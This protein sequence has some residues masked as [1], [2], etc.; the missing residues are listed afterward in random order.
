MSKKLDPEI[1]REVRELVADG[2]D[3]SAAFLLWFLSNMYRIDKD[4]APDMV[5]DS[6][7][8]KGIDGILVDDATGEVVIFSS[9]FYR[10]TKAKTQGDNDLRNLV[11]ASDWFASP[12]KVDMLLESTA[13]AELKALVNRSEVRRKLE[14]GYSLGLVLV[15]SAPLDPEAIEYLGL[16]EGNDPPVSAWDGRRMNE[17][18]A[19]LDADEK[20]PGTFEFTVLPGGVFDQ[21]P[22]DGIR[23][24]I[25]PI[26]ATE[27]AAM[28]GLDDRTLFARN[29]RLPIGSTRVN[30]D[31]AA[32]IESTADHPRF[33]LY[34]NGVTILC[35]SLSLTG[36]ALSVTNYSIV[37]GC[38]SAIA[39]YDNKAHLSDDLLVLAKVV[40]VGPGLDAIADEITYRSN[41]Q[42]PTNM[43]DQ[44]S[45]DRI[46]V[47]LQRQFN[48]MFGERVRYLRKRG[49][50]FAAGVTKLDNDLAAQILLAF[51]VKRPWNS[52]QKWRLFDQ[53]YSAVFTRHTTA[54][55]IYLAFRLY[56]VIE[57]VLDDVKDE[58][59][60]SY[61]LAR[62][63]LLYVMRRILDQDELAKRI[64]EAPSLPLAHHEDTILDAFTQLARLIIRQFNHIVDREQEAGYFDY[65]SDLKSSD[66]VQ[67]MA[68]DILNGY[69]TAVVM[70]P[71]ASVR[72]LL[73]QKGNLDPDTYFQSN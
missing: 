3:E 61:K 20:V 5:C 44:R 70:Y 47:E 16:H 34:H 72:S 56:Q 32:A 27:I 10:T 7:N 22:S 54:P 41:N 19:R 57:S 66:R 53:D 2:R 23:V 48:D 45:N 9:K 65:K 1:R 68:A 4:D 58:L 33:L 42:N 25:L 30:R 37:N 51:S 63:F 29:V 62:F 35:D 18:F 13:S 40:Q 15:S 24:V 71:E 46:Q 21:T 52:H 28:D 50:D 69:E 38:Q 49:E 60:R 64:L 17:R 14:A 73:T 11:G 26:K 43:R 8:D 59:I 6:R 55:R 36:A 39:F 67:A 31:I 12:E